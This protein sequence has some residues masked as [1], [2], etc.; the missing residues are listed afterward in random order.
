LIGKTTKRFNQMSELPMAE[1]LKFLIPQLGLKVGTFARAMNVSDTNVRNYLDRG[2]K[3]SSEFLERLVQTFDTINPA[4]LLTG[5]GEPFLPGTEPTQ[6]ISS[7][8]NKGSINSTG[9]GTNT[10]NNISLDDCKRELEA[11]RRDAASYQR[12]IELL[13]GQLDS[14]DALI[15]A[16][17]EMLVLLRSQ[18]NRPN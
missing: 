4:W 8:K 6:N 14:K 18:F 12:E 16:K 15:A 11:V 5:K 7:P 1:R 10:I 9:G 2:S 13:K 3:P 17:E